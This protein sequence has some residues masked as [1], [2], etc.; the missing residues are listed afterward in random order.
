MQEPV[1][2]Q[3][4]VE[5]NAFPVLAICL[6][7]CWFLSRRHRPPRPTPNILAPWPKNV[8]KTF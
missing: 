8:K 5:L 3:G 1:C 2:G 4:G 7:V 6:G